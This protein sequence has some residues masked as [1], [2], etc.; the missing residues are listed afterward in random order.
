M[1]QMPLVR[2]MFEM[3]SVVPNTFAPVNVVFVCACDYHRLHK[4][5]H[6]HRQVSLKRTAND[7]AQDAHH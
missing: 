5:R 2:R 6:A 4:R 7:A 3:V 1:L